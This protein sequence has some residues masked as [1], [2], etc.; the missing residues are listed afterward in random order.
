[1][2]LNCSVDTVILTITN[3]QALLIHMKWVAMV[4][5]DLKKGQ[6]IECNRCM[7]AK[8]N[9]NVSMSTPTRNAYGN[10]L[11]LS[12][13]YFWTTPANL[14]LEYY[15]GTE[16]FSIEILLFSRWLMVVPSIDHGNSVPDTCVG[17]FFRACQS[18]PTAAAH[19]SVYT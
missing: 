18:F 13:K 12:R 7:A 10:Y 16:N 9:T 17:G 8:K 6:F 1:M 2:L 5:L 4:K 3:T 11:F 19:L 14:L 15:S